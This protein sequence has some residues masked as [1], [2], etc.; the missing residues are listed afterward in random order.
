MISRFFSVLPIFYCHFIQSFSR[1]A[2][3]LTSMLKIS[4]TPT[5][6]KLMNLV[7]EFG[8]GDCSKNEAKRAFVSTKGPTGANYLFFDHVSLTV[9]NIVS[10][11]AKNVSN[12]LASDAKN[13]LD[14]LRQAFIEMP[15][16]QHFD[17]EQY[18]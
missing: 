1:I 5:T 4:P 7:D 15:I 8:R 10:N 13:A 18:I 12:Y 9:S 14:Q 11:P 16:L 2:A 17:P 3:L 6:Q